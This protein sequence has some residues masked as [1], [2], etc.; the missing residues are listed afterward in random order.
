MTDDTKTVKI[1]R[2]GSSSYGDRNSLP[3]DEEANNNV[4]LD[5]VLRKKKKHNRLTH[6]QGNESFWE[7]FCDGLRTANI[8]AGN[9]SGDSIVTLCSDHP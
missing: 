5:R 1:K 9:Y 6:S 7:I 2:D 4:T 3:L 8:I